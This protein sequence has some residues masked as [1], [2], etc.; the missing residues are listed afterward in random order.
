MAE[1]ECKSITCDS[2][3]DRFS[4]KSIEA[5]DAEGASEDFGSYAGPSNPNCPDDY[6]WG[7]LACIPDNGYGYYQSCS[8]GFKWAGSYCAPDAADFECET[9][10]YATGD[11]DCIP[12]KTPSTPTLNIVPDV[13]DF[14]N[15]SIQVVNNYEGEVDIEIW[16]AIDGE[17]FYLNVTKVSIAPGD[18]AVAISLLEIGEKF[19]AYAVFKNVQIETDCSGAVQSNIAVAYAY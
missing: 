9:G 12:C 19:E 11:G 13:G 5:D 3:D 4:F 18:T 7:G 14:F 6:I 15:I 17:D 10:Y 8:T 1:T 2:C 16:N